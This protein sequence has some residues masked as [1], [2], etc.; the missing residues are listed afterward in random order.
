MNTASFPPRDPRTQKTPQYR[1]FVGALK[2]TSSTSDQAEFNTQPSTTPV[3]EMQRSNQGYLTEF[4]EDQ[5]S[6]V[7]DDHQ[8]QNA[9]RNS[10]NDDSLEQEAATSGRY[11]SPGFIQAASQA[12]RG[13]FGSW[14]FSQVSAV[15]KYE[16]VKYPSLTRSVEMP[17]GFPGSPMSIEPSE[18]GDTASGSP[19]MSE[20]SKD[21][22][23]G[24]VEN[25]SESRVSFLSMAGAV[26]ALTQSSL[27]RG[28]TLSSSVSSPS[29]RNRMSSPTPSMSARAVRHQHRSSRPPT[30][31]LSHFN[32]RL[33][34]IV[35]SHAYQAPDSD[36]EFF[37]VQREMIT[38][39]GHRYPP[40]MHR[41]HNTPSKDSV[42][43]MGLDDTL[44]RLTLKGFKASPALPPKP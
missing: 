39:P 24:R 27:G 20:R 30:P 7:G 34:Q 36:E 32:G 13:R 43:D 33:D 35:H 29:H 17:G 19:S 4:N 1:D 5:D 16:Q 12:L 44:H 37:T 21:T 40:L 11:Q 23:V 18:V 41:S 14:P 9:A 8:E 15:E 10:D 25:R 6:A 22:I 2:Q 28:T 3:A 42:S 31:T 26:I 38:S